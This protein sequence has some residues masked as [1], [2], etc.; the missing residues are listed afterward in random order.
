MFKRIAAFMLTLCLLTSVTALAGCAPR[1]TEQQDRTQ[2]QSTQDYIGTISCTGSTKGV[3]FDMPVSDANLDDLL[4]QAEANLKPSDE[5]APTLPFVWDDTT[6]QLSYNTSG[7]TAHFY[8]WYSDDETDQPVLIGRVQVSVATGQV[9]YVH[10]NNKTPM[11]AIITGRE[12]EQ[13]IKQKLIA[14]IM[15]YIG[16]SSEECVVTGKT[17]YCVYTDET[18]T[19]Q[20]NNETVE[21]IHVLAPEEEYVIYSA[22][23]RRR[24]GDHLLNGAWIYLHRFASGTTLTMTIDRESQFTQ[25]DFAAMN[26]CDAAYVQEQMRAYLKDRVRE[27]WVMDDATVKEAYF[28]KRDGVLRYSATLDV[29]AHT[30]SDG[31]NA[32]EELNVTATIV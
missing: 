10:L 5:A 17:T 22:H 11:A 3:I 4:E 8:D 29:T 9:S 32:H 20:V 14:C 12:T 15:P 25:E 27:G 13:E 21:G 6:Y 18:R 26:R 31:Q 28:W 16:W 23:I 1:Q 24:H 30:G 19:E 7:S 2:D